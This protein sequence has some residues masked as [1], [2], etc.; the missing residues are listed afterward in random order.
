MV[1]SFVSIH[2]NLLNILSDNEVEHT[3]SENDNKAIL[4]LTNLTQTVGEEG[5]KVK[6]SSQE[7]RF[8]LSFLREP[9]SAAAARETRLTKVNLLKKYHRNSASVQMRLHP[10]L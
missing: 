4:V 2:C 3:N 1:V 9:L 6:F 10:N 5:L 7:M 8:F